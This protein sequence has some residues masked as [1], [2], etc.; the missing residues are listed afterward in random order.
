MYWGVTRILLS[1]GPKA[2]LS[3]VFQFLVGLS[4]PLSRLCRQ[5]PFLLL[6]FSLSLHLRST[7]Q[8]TRRNIDFVVYMNLCKPIAPICSLWERFLHRHY[9]GYPDK[10]VNK[11]Q[12]AE[13]SSK[14]RDAWLRL[15][16][17]SCTW[18]NKRLWKQRKDHPR[19]IIPFRRDG[20]IRFNWWSSKIHR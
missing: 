14:K 6:N 16:K 7:T 11:T 2:H 13:H 4:D 19:A 17:G 3:L 12:R 20:E 9:L 5:F 1:L 15:Q 10:V 8:W 18:S